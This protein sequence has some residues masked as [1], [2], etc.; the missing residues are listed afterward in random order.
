KRFSKELCAK[1][2]IDGGVIDRSSDLKK[3][4]DRLPDYFSSV[5]SDNYYDTQISGIFNNASSNDPASFKKLM[6]QLAV[7]ADDQTASLTS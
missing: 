1:R 6:E 7:R 3:V 2:L 4:I 5:N